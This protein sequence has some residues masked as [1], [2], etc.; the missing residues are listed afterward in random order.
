MTRKT[1]AETMTD[2]DDRY[3]DRY[4]RHDKRD[5]VRD[6]DRDDNDR[7]DNDRGDDRGN[8]DNTTTIGIIYFSKYTIEVVN[9]ETNRR[10]L[11]QQQT[12]HYLLSY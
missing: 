10:G 1:T 3:Y 5:I 7:D 12:T 6:D 2:D 9:T 11:E 4:D 8:D